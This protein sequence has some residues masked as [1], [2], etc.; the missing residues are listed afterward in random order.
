[1]FEVIYISPSC[2]QAIEFIE[3]LIL[4]LRK[5]EICDIEID[6]DNLRLK[7]DKFIVSAVYIEG[8]NLGISHHMTEYY[9][10]KVSGVDYP[11]KRIQEKAQER[12]KDLKCRFREG[13]KEI[14]DGELIEIL[15]EA[16]NHD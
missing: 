1:M 13:T 8:G 16:E 12:L 9:I 15:K 5:R 10:D 14:S 4:D 7:S 3:R 2:K 11:S 6:R